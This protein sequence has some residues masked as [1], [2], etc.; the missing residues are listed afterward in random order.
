MSW[1][2]TFFRRRE[3]ERELDREIQ[4]HLEARIADL[5]AAGREPEAARREALVEFGGVERAKEGC[6]DERSGQWLEMA[7][8]DMRYA[9]R[10]LHREPGLSATILVTLALGIGGFTTTF[11]TLDGL[12]LHP[13]DLPA[14]NEIVTPREGPARAVP[15]RVLFASFLEW[16]DDN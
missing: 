4:Q 15:G 8:Q 10:R 3:A 12:V 16:R 5:I 7:L 11:S 2:R 9:L 14:L 13:R 6:R 1:F